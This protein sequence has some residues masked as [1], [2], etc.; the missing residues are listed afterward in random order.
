MCFM[1]ARCGAGLAAATRASISSC[2]RSGSAPLAS[3]SFMRNS[4]PEVVM[5]I[6]PRW[7]ARRSRTW[8]GSTLDSFERVATA[9]VTLSSAAVNPSVANLVSGVVGPYAAILMSCF[10]T[11]VGDNG[12]E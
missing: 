12:W 1:K 7:A 6:A 11:A 4:L 2:V 8:P 10:L 3:C 9:F 5:T